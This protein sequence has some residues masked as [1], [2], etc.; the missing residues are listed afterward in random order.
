MEEKLLSFCVTCMN[1]L[2]QLEKTLAYNLNEIKNLA[3]VN[4]CLVNYNSQDSLDKYIKNNFTSHIK[5]GKLRYFYTDQPETFHVSIAKNLAHRL[6]TGNIL[7]NLDGD[8][9]IS[10]AHVEDLIKLFNKEH[11]IF[12]HGIF[13]PNWF[14][15]LIRNE[16][17]NGSYGRIA[18]QNNIFFD[19][20]G[21]DEDLFPI[22]YEDN[23][24]INR[25]KKCGY[26]KVTPQYNWKT[27]IRNTKN[28]LKENIPNDIKNASWHSIDS[29][30][31]KIAKFKLKYN[32]K[33][34]PEGMKKFQGILN[35]DKEVIL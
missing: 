26:K 31:K 33:R 11:N 28:A 6:G 1:R 22:G 16:G 19:L 13:Y 18:L 17:H 2:Y 3:G 9:Y 12:V 34:N 14:R 25:L 32:M 10:E 15:K 27:A 30:N 21:Y 4:I 23:D 24:L 5:S 7:M 20:N 35:F 29:M 8:N